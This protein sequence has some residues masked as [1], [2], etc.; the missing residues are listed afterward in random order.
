MKWLL[1]IRERAGTNPGSFENTLCRQ[2]RL[3]PLLLFGGFFRRPLGGLLFGFRFGFLPGRSLLF[4]R[5]LGSWPS[6]RRGFRGG[7]FLFGLLA[8]DRQLL[9]FGF[10]H[11]LCLAAQLFVVLQP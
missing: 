9:F 11:L 2:K 10:H 7:S 6:R 1:F 4:R 3:A 8:Y 5:F